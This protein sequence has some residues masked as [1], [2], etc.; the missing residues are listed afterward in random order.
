[1]TKEKY[2]ERVKQRICVQC[3]KP[4]FGNIRCPVCAE[5]QREACKK[6]RRSDKSR[7]AK[8]SKMRG[9]NKEYYATLKDLGLCR[10]GHAVAIGF[11][12]CPRCIER[13]RQRQSQKREVNRE[14]YNA[15]MREYHKKQREERKAN[16]LCTR[17]GKPVPHG[18]PFQEC[19][20]CRNRRLKQKRKK[21]V[22]K[23]PRA[24]WTAYGLCYHCGKPAMD[25]KKVCEKCYER[26]MKLLEKANASP[27]AAAA[28]KEYSE[29]F[30]RRMVA[31]RMGK[32]RGTG[33]AM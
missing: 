11:N 32:E 27:L 29:R 30:Y 22:G 17:C 9:Y 6:Y 26:D 23:I 13:D 21:K 12:Q 3:G 18:S 33:V 4:T 10:C 24:E 1:M 5:K 7:K 8:N 16:G 15:Y 2:A 31:A 19:I 14:A 25:G 20:E 28:K